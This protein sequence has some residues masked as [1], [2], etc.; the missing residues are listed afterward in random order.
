MLEN[1]FTFFLFPSF[2]HVYNFSMAGL[3]NSAFVSVS[4]VPWYYETC[5]LSYNH[6]Q[7]TLTILSFV[8]FF[9]LFIVFF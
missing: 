5:K 6:L 4:E 7:F 2:P 1:N 9:K 8:R 3:Y